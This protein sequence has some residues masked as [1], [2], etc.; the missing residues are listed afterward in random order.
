MSQLMLPSGVPAARL[1]RTATLEPTLPV[2]STI[3]GVSDQPPCL[4]WLEQLSRLDWNGEIV[5]FSQTEG[6]STGS[7][8]PRCQP[9]CSDHYEVRSISSLRLRISQLNWTP[10][11][12]GEERWKQ[13]PYPDLP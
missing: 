2:R 11:R 1:C 7:S 8:P 13:L 10:A 3:P 12:L 4:D 9:S 6:P 5:L